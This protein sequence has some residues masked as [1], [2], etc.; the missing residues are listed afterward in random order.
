MRRAPAARSLG[1]APAAR[2]CSSGSS[3]TRWC[4]CWSKGF[5]GPRA[6]RS[7]YVREFVAPAHRVAG[8]LGQPVDL[9]RDRGARGAGRR[10]ARLPLRALR[11]PGPADPRRAGGAAGG[12][13]A[14]RRRHR[15]PLPLRRERLRR[16]LVQALLGLDEPPWRL[17]GAGAILLVHAYSMYVYFYL[18]I[19][20]GARLARRARSSRRRPASARAAG[21]RSAAW[22]CRCLRPALA[23]AALLTFM[24][25]L[26]SFSAPYLFGGG[27]RVMT[28]QIVATRLNGDDRARDGGDRL[29]HA[30]GARSRCGCFRATAGDRRAAGGRRARRRRRCRCAA[31]G[32]AR[33]RG[34]SGWGLAALLLL[35][36]LTLLLVSFVPAGTWTVEPLPPAY[37][38]AQLSP[39]VQDPVRLRPLLNSLWLATAG[40]GRGARGHRAGRRRPQRA[41]PGPGRARDRAAAR[42]ALGG[43]GDRLR[44][45]AGHRVQRPRAA[46]RPVRPGRHAL[47]P[48]ARLPRAEPADHQPGDPGR[49]S[50]ARSLAG[51]GR[52][53]ARAPDAGARCGG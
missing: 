44:H 34:V 26:A 2:C 53:L 33:A 38:L 16:A 36:H 35:P 23:G 45:R 52:R 40:H 1:A 19:R 14:A 18:F 11:L 25:A 21:A 3:S 15:V 12:A 8:A 37:T 20:A 28:T 29:A 5:A 48:A 31:A 42:A 17:Q 6:G 10:S 9:A 22:R 27:F 49:L 4:S 50:R 24:T 43:A 13:A 30:A 41:P 32:C 7:D 51:R 39:L 47:D 46:G